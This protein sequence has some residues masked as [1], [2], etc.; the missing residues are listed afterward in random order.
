MRTRLIGASLVGLSMI[1]AFVLHALAKAAP[2]HQSPTTIELIL[3]AMIVLAGLPGM[4]MLVE[5]SALFG[6]VDRPRR[7]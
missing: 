5:G 2:P 4:G 6:D 3:G 7:G 1:A